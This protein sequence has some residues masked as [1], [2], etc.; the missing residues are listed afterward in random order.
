MCGN[1]EVNPIGFIFRNKHH[2]KFCDYIVITYISNTNL[3]QN[4]HE[5]INNNTSVFITT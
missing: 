3:K 1:I 2:Y 5:E 4:N